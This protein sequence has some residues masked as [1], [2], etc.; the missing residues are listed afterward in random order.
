MS[1]LMVATEAWESSFCP[2]FIR[3]SCSGNYCVKERTN[4]ERD[5]SCINAPS[6]GGGLG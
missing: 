3:E 6:C 1:F 2:S 5:L 4:D